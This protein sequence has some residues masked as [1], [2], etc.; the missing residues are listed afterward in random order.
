MAGGLSALLVATSAETMTW[1]FVGSGAV[2]TGLGHWSWGER[3]GRGREKVTHVA[4]HLLPEK[5]VQ[6]T[7]R[8]PRSAFMALPVLLAEA[9]PVESPESRRGPRSKGVDWMLL[10]PRNE[11]C[12]GPVHAHWPAGASARWGLPSLPH[13]RPGF[14]WERREARTQVQGRGRVWAQ[15]S[16]SLRSGCVVLDP[17]PRRV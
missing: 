3:T 12:Q 9:G 5:G 4:G 8:K 14:T 6:Q 2:V 11:S 16:S 1:V 17:G 10:S 15:R 13:T 7:G